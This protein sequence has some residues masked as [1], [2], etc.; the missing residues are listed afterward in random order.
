MEK[1]FESL[2]EKIFTKQMKATL[3]ESFDKAITEKSEARA[4]VLALEL[5]ESKIEE[6]K[7]VFEAE[8]KEAK[9][10][11]EKDLAEHLDDY[12]VRVVEDF[13]TEAKSTIEDATEI[14]K[15]NMLKEAMSAMVVATSVDVLRIEEAKEKADEDVVANLEA[16]LKESTVKYD[17]LIEENIKLE[18]EAAELLRMGLVKEMTESMSIVESEKFVKIA[19]LVEFTESAEYV[20]KLDA[21]KESI[22]K[23]VAEKV[24]KEVKPLTESKSKSDYSHLI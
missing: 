24:Q 4:E 6:F 11:A 13:V 19:N 23:P 14:K 10:L 12:L 1:L 21:I 16:D 9:E 2:D 15:A 7:T 8:A 17:K 22:S 3:L 18:K 20:T 5:A